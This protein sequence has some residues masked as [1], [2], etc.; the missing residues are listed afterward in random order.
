[1]ADL[2][3]VRAI[4]YGRVQGVYF[5]AFTQ[6][7]ASELG[8]TGYVRNLS[9]G[10]VVEV[11]AEGEKA[12]LERLIGHLKMGPPGARVERVETDW[13]EHSGAYADFTIRYS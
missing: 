10:R 2:A 12:K 5:R 4:V 1:M 6:R 11:Q 7:R 13:S 3:A 8:L 9:G